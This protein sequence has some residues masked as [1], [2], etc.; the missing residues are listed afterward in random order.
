MEEH[1]E[2]GAESEHPDDDRRG[3]LVKVS[4][5]C[6]GVSA[7]LVGFPVVRSFVSPSLPQPRVDG[8]VKVADDIALLDVG[9]PVRVTFV[10]ELQDA[11]TGTITP[12][13]ARYAK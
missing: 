5:A 10:Q 9:V 1:S 2:G 7:V 11:D 8:W 6:A 4:A 3:F 12:R 13:L